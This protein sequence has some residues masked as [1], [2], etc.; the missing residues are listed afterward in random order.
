MWDERYA[1]PDYVYGTEPNDFLA[2]VAPRIPK[3]RV[4]SIADGEGRNGVF[5]ATLG[6]DVTSVDASAVGL[7]KAQRLAAARGVHLTTQVVDLA[8]YVIE[9]G[10]WSGIVSIF[11]H[12][13]PPLRRRVHTQVV[14]GLAPGGVF[15]L[16]AYSPD[17]LR[18]GTG[19]PTNPE[20]MPTLDALRAELDGLELTHAAALEREVQE[21]QFHR[22]RS[23]V[24][25]VV[26]RKP[27]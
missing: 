14:R 10:A 6:H 24:V 15:I 5:L 23:A 17:Q 7:A 18:H 22:G 3:G 12:L 21:G 4:L 9:P 26:A 11:V 19:G 13:P 20:L 25:Q 8:D 2:S 1:S 27:G 16:E